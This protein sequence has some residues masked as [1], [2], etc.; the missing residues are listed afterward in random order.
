MYVNKYIA[1]YSAGNFG[2]PGN[3]KQTFWLH[4]LT[5]SIMGA[6]GLVG[7]GLVHS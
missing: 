3:V 6:R 1:P 5:S 4:P 7:L 2:L